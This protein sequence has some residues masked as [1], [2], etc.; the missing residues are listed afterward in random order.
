MDKQ[1]RIP[2]KVTVLRVMKTEDVFDKPVPEQVS[3]APN[4]CARLKEGQVFIIDE[5]GECSVD[6]PCTWAWHDLFPVIT[7]MQTGGHFVMKK[8]PGIQYSCCTDGTMPVVFKIE[9]LDN[10]HQNE[11][12]IQEK[13]FGEKEGNIR[14]P[15]KITVVKTMMPGDIYKNSLPEVDMPHN[16]PMLKEGQ[17]F[18]VGENGRCP[19]NFPSFAWHNLNHYVLSLQLGGNFPEF[20]KGTVYACST[21]GLFPVF[22]HLER[23]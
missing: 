9:Y 7:A 18:M 8:R 23:V 22:F 2:L 21:D 13:Y 19:E 6:F 10:E 14:C 4:C 20:P 11:K 16:E 3:H 12:N 5:N 1:K 17:S 15:L